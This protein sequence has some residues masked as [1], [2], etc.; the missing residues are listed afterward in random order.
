M[1]DCDRLES[2]R[3]II[4]IGSLKHLFPSP[5]QLSQVREHL[6]RRGNENTLNAESIPK[7]A[8]VV[9]GLGALEFTR[10]PFGLR[11]APSVFQRLMTVISRDE[12]GETLRR[13]TSHDVFPM[14]WLRKGV[15]EI[16]ILQDHPN[17]G[18]AVV[19][20]FWVAPER[21]KT[22][23]KKYA[24]ASA[25]IHAHPIHKCDLDR[26][27]STLPRNSASAILIRLIQSKAKA[28]TSL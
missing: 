21:R 24:E 14:F 1:R 27:F 5:V 9:D 11:D 17:H 10:V 12:F 2:V 7:T 16:V 15:T 19:H 4:T 8:F 20:S 25:G 26:F 22:C 28:S 6:T 13:A 3:G 23:M 18:N